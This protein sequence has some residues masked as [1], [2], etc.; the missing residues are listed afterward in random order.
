MITL[1]NLN[2]PKAIPAVFNTEEEFIKY[3][4]DE[5]LWSSLPTG[6]IPTMEKW[7]FAKIIDDTITGENGQSEDI[8][9]WEANMNTCIDFWNNAVQG[10][11]VNIGEQL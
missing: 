9:H 10:W 7:G 3:T 8:Y 6:E 5:A 1:K 4:V 11:E 2:Q